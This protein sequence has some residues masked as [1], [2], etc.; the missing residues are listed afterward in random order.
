MNTLSS[1]CSINDIN[2]NKCNSYF[3]K[4]T[5]AFDRTAKMYVG[6]SGNRINIREKMRQ[7]DRQQTIALCFTPQARVA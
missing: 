3:I 2:N 4:Q 5:S 1:S 7:T 6:C